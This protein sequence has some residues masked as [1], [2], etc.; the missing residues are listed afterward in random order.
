MLD[1]VLCPM[2]TSVV[3]AQCASTTHRTNIAFR[4]KR[5]LTTLVNSVRLFERG[6]QVAESRKAFKRALEQVIR[7]SKEFELL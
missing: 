3:L 2:S 6:P 7:A 1:L 5:P 4:H